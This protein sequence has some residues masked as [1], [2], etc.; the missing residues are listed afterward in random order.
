[1]VLLHG[2]CTH[3]DIQRLS[4][5]GVCVLPETARKKLQSWQNNL[6]ENLQE[7]K[8]KWIQGG[9]QTFQLIGDNW[10]KNIVPSYRTSQQ[11]TQSIHLFN[12]IGMITIILTVQ[13]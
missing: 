11:A 4:K 6:D 12:V 13:T 5:I 10:D 1:M 9:S 2:G 7:I 8:K 3:R